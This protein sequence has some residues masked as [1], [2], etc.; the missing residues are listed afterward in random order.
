MQNLKQN[1]ID[2]FVLGKIYADE[3]KMQGVAVDYLPQNLGDVPT[4]YI[5]PKTERGEKICAEMNEF[6][7]KNF[8]K[9]RT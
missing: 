6:I 9:W 5:F 2:A 1:K 3:L 8:C 4:A 7:K